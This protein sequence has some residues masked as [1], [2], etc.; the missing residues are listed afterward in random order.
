[1]STVLT[2]LLMALPASAAV[3][4][5]MH[6]QARAWRTY[7]RSIAAQRRC[8]NGLCTTSHNARRTR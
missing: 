6:P 7:R 1:M 4:L 2:L 5:W 3:R 8:C